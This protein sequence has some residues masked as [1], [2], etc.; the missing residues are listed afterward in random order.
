MWEKKKEKEK[1]EKEKEH[2]PLGTKWPPKVVSSDARRATK[3]IGGY[4][5]RDSRSTL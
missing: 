3:G 4:T 5:R 2:T 1:E